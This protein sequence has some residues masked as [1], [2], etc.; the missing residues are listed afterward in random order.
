[1]ET[2]KKIALCVWMGLAVSVALA[3]DAGRRPMA[4]GEFARQLESSAVQEGAEVV[5][6]WRLEGDAGLV[7][8]DVFRS[9]GTTRKAER[10]NPEFLYDTLEYGGTYEY[11]DSPPPV[12]DTYIYQIEMVFADGSRA[13]SKPVPLA[14][15]PSVQPAPRAAKLPRYR[16]VSPPVSTDLLAQASLTA[17]EIQKASLKRSTNTGGRIKITVKDPGLYRLAAATLAEKFGAETNEVQ[18]WIGQ[19]FLRLSSQGE[20]C[21]WIP[22]TNNEA[23]YFYNPGYEDLYTLHNVFWLERESPGLVIPSVQGVPPDAAFA[24]LSVVQTDHFERQLLQQFIALQA[25][26]D[27]YWFW[28]KMTAA[29]TPTPTSLVFQTTRI[30]TNA[31]EALL[32][33]HLQGASNTGVPNEHHVVVSLN[34]TEIGHAIWEQD[35]PHLTNFPV[36]V[37]VLSNGNNT[38]TLRAVLDAGV[39]YGTVLLDHFSLT[40]RMDAQ[41]T[42]DYLQVPLA[43]TTNQH[44]SAFTT[45]GI[46]VVEILDSRQ[47]REVENIRIDMEADDLFSVS[48]TASTNGNMGHVAFTPAGALT[49][50]VVES[51]PPSV[52]RATTNRVDYLLITHPILEADTR[53]L[54]DFRAGTIS[55]LQTCTVLI[56]DV[57]NE[58]SNGLKTPEAIRRFMA[59]AAQNWAARPQYVLLAGSSSL[60]YVNSLNYNGSLV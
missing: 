42:N 29:T 26:L 40:Y 46:R 44:V 45:N 20:K 51:V 34:G 18:D 22:E 4:E 49:N 56:D 12:A 10:I 57:Y 16:T 28:F 15:Q 58:F 8:F 11:R 33:I 3:Q 59:Y 60:D 24:P 35:L 27:D 13:R 5:L 19:N 25:E 1:M 17:D 48:F 55:N 47:I 31:A 23:L 52:L 9:S 14:F 6:S 32:D 39:P 2:I 38:L 30:D 54:A 37:A 50:M 53:R 21:S 43:E 7:G 36:P 41:A